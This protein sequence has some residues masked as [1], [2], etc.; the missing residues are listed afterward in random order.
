MLEAWQVTV[1]IAYVHKFDQKVIYTSD[2]K[3]NEVVFETTP[4]KYGI[5]DDKEEW[6]NR[7]GYGG[8]GWYGY[9]NKNDLKLIPD[10]EFLREYL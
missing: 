4:T 10:Q 3:G 2:S 6:N 7:A 1:A 5:P 8:D 9:H